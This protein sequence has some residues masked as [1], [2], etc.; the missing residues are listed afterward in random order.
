MNMELYK[1]FY[2]TAKYGNISKASEHLYITQPAVSRSIKQ[3]EEE[4][5][6]PLFFRTSKGVIL[7]PEGE[8]LY[9]Y[10]DQAFSFITTGEKKIS[11]VKNLLYGEIR[12]GVSD[13]LCKHYLIPHLKL[14]N[15]LHPAIKIHVICP[16]TPGIINLLKSGKIDFGIINLP[17]N[18][19]QLNFKSIMEVQDCFVTGQKYKSLSRK[20]QPLSTIIQHPLLLLEKNSNSRLFID[21][22]FKTNSVSVIPDFE[23]GNIDLLVQFAKYDFGIACVIKNFVEEE[24]EKGRLFEV[25]PIEKIPSRHIGVTWLKNVPLSPAAKEMISNLEYFETTE[26]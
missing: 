18:D 2:Y 12:I 21:Q 4:L 16:T 13:T 20:A 1:S 19:E 24:L 17:Y 5:K 11:D 8:I 7:T 23:L 26:F 6:C 9:Q 25:K 3:L 15:T 10:V 14:F 22:Y